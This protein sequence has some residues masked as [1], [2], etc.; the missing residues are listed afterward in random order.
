MYELALIDYSH[1]KFLVMEK[2]IGKISFY[3]FDGTVEEVVEYT[4]KESYLNAIKKELDC[5]P[6]GFQ[7]QTLTND[8]EIRKTVDDLI[9]GAYG[10]DNPHTLDWYL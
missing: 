6:S 9:Y 4:A 5:N 2:V 1:L 3:G 8:A 10:E 7:H